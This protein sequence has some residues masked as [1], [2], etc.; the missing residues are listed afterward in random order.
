MNRKKKILF[1]VDKPNWA[2]HFIVKTWAKLLT[3]Y[4]CYIA[5]ERDYQIRPRK[6]NIFDIIKNKISSV[7]QL[8][9]VQFK[10]DSSRRFS[11]PIYKQP[12]V[13]KVSNNTK[14]NITH[15]DVII[16]MAYYLQYTSELP[17]TSDKKLIGIYTDSFPHE[18]PSF[19][20]KRNQ[21][22]KELSREEFYYTYLKPYDG[23]VVGN[24]N[25]FEDYKSYTPNIVV[26]NGIYLQNDFIENH[27]VGIKESLTIGWTG[28]P[29]RPMKGFRDF[30]EPAIKEVQKTGRNI[31]LKT[32]FSGAYE[33][34]LNFYKDVD[35][36]LIASTA[37]TGP[38]LF[39]EASLCSIPSISTNIGFPKMIIQHN[40]N[41][42]IVERDITAFKNAIIELYDNREKLTQFSKRIKKDYLEKMSNEISIKNLTKFLNNI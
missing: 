1:I 28:T 5:Y 26:A 42:M 12:P 31:T 30:I 9:E 15:F 27:N 36:V 23:I 38:S 37:D 7:L 29:D 3:D 20:Y 33:D 21:E 18:G 14:V 35:L 39:S 22:L 25:L 16:E 10:I 4:E 8:R 13:Y 2:Y 32:K 17:F 19:D 11:Y 6:F 40:V 41:G 34:L 24:N